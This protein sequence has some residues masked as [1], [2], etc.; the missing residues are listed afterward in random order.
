M[1]RQGN[2]KGRPIGNTVGTEM[3][4]T[5]PRRGCQ[6]TFNSLSSNLTI[7]CLNSGNLHAGLTLGVSL[8]IGAQNPCS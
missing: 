8:V 6:L 4:T 1:T 3:S 5:V 7:N 2:F